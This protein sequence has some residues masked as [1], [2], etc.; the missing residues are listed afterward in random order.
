MVRKKVSE[1][2]NREKKE[3]ERWGTQRGNCVI[4]LGGNNRP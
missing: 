3:M 1:K 4:G 2:E